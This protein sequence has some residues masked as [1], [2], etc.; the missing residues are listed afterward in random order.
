M[1]RIH[2]ERPAAPTP[3]LRE[4]KKEAGVITKVEKKA[5]R[6]LTHFVE[7]QYAATRAM[8]SRKIE[9][10]RPNA[11]NSKLA[12]LVKRAGQEMKEL[13]ANARKR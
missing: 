11:Q 7:E 3:S 1:T 2:R 12:K 4:V 9:P 8:R 5:L 10:R 6:P 13:S